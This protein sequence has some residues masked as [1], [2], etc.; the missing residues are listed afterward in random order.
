MLVFD[1]SVGAGNAT[2]VFKANGDTVIEY[3]IEVKFDSADTQTFMRLTAQELLDTYGRPDFIWASPPCV[4]FS[5]ASLH[6]HWIGGKNQYI[7]GTPTAE[8]GIAVAKHVAELI[9]ELQPRLGFIVENPRGVLRKLDVLAHYE[10]NTVHYCSY[11]DFRQKPTDLWGS[12][13]DWE[14]RPKCK[15]GSPCHEPAPRGSRSGTLGLPKSQRATVPFELAQE[16]RNALVEKLKE[17]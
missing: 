9:D 8:N 17:R 7:P 10:L 3:N 15:R 13:P 11:G 6:R 16:I 12:V 14:P 5:P 1:F 4:A 2:C